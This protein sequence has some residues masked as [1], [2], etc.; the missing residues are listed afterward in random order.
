VVTAGAS[1]AAQ[2]ITVSLDVFLG[3]WF[4]DKRIGIAYFRDLLVH[5]PN[6][7]TVRRHSRDTILLTDGYRRGAHAHVVKMD[8]GQRSRIGRFRRLRT[9][10]A[11][12]YSRRLAVTI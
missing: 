9:T 4:L 8:T 2:R 7:D 10:T 1:Y 5:S 11:T 6:S 3:E 12:T